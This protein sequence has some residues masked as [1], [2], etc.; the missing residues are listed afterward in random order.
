MP[1]D[2][3]TEYHNIPAPTDVN[4]VGRMLSQGQL[5]IT[6]KSLVTGE[7]LT[8]RF[9]SQRP[10]AEG[11]TRWQRAPWA[12]AKTC[13]VVR[14]ADGRV[15]ARIQP[16]RGTFRLMPPYDEAASWAIRQILIL[17]SGDTPSNMAEYT[18]AERC[19]RCFIELTDPVSIERGIGPDCFG[20]A[21]GS[22]HTAPATATAA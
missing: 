6:V 20:H 19:G 21:T 13:K 4:R 8:L 5:L 10:P 16:K 22:K 18:E 7:H 1:T 14:E 11:E 3:I 12:E 2:L 17:A 15:V 9:M